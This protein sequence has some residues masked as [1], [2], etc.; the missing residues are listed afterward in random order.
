[1]RF[2]KPSSSVSPTFKSANLTGRTESA[3]RALRQTMGIA[4]CIKQIDTLAAEYPAQ[5][6]YL[7]LTYNGQEDD[8][9][10]GGEQS[11]IVLGSGPYRIGSSV[12]FDWCSVNAAHTVRKLGYKTVVVNCNPETV[13]TDYNESDRLYFEE[14]TL[15]SVLAICAKEDPW[16]VAVSMGGQVSNNL[17]VPLWECGIRVLGTSPSSIDRAE[18]RHKFSSLLGSIGCRTARVGRSCVSRGCHRLRRKSRLSGDRPALLRTQ[19]LGD[20]CGVERRRVA[21]VSRQ[22]FQKYLRVIPSC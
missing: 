1:M 21:A 5:T 3:I 14:L 8:I 20:E 13:S 4:P 9:Q 12:E 18:D 16:G 15:E 17:A 2:S 6:N 19:R 22:G 10:P 7:Y 11:V